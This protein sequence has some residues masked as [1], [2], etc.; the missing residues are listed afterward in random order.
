MRGR[1]LRVLMGAGFTAIVYGIMKPPET[2]CPGR[3]AVGMTSPE[4]EL[5]HDINPVTE[6][7]PPEEF[8]D[9]ED[10]LRYLE[11]WFKNIANRRSRSKALIS[12][13]RM[14]K[15]AVLDRFVNLMFWRDY[16]VV[17]FYIKMKR[18]ETTL[19]KFTEKYLEV[20]FHRTSLLVGN[21]FPLGTPGI[22]HRFP[23]EKFQLNVIRP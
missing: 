20:F 1:S 10:I 4:F 16:G 15:S 13:R 22:T 14:G 19:R 8:T 21:E 18:E 2:T 5:T 9:R 23:V 11:E 6:M 3:L 12:P 7:M 17:P